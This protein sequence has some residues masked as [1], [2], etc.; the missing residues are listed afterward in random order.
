[1]PRLVCIAHSFLQEPLHFCNARP[2]ICD[3][4]NSGEGHIHW[5]TRGTINAAMTVC[6]EAWVLKGE[7]NAAMRRR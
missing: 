2:S 4:D 6:D 5:Y 7:L 3:V 1:M